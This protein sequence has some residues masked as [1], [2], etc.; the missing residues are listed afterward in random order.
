MATEPPPQGL[1]IEIKKG[2]VYVF[3]FQ[4]VCLK[5]WFSGVYTRRYCF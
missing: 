2:F 3:D 5:K 4:F 1:D